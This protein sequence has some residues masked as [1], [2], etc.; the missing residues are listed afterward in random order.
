[1]PAINITDLNNA[2]L[3][4][5]T[6]AGV[7]TSTAPTVTDR[8]GNVKAT[9]FGAVQTLK[10]FNVRGPWA[11]ATAYALKDVY[12]FG[13][14]AYVAVAAHTSTTVAADLASGY[15]TVHQ[16]ATRED[17]A[18]SGGAGL[19][20]GANQVVPSIAGLR[21][22]N[23][24]SASKNAFVTGYYVAGDGGGGPYYYDAA[25]TTTVDNGGTTI[26]A[27][28][29]GRWKL[30]HNGTV[31]VKQFG[32]KGISTDDFTFLQSAITTICGFAGTLIFNPGEYK[33]SQPLTFP[34]TSW[35]ILGGGGQT[36]TAIRETAGNIRLFDLTNCNGP[37]KLIEGITFIGRA[38]GVASS[39][40]VYANITNGVVL[41]DCWFL[42]LSIGVQKLNTS[43][44]VNQFDC[45]YEANT[46]A[47]AYDDGAECI[48]SNP[49]FYKNFTDLYLTGDLATFVCIN[50]NVIGSVGFSIRLISASYGQ[51]TNLTA[52]PDQGGVSIPVLVSLEGTSQHNQFNGITSKGY[53]KMLVKMTAGGASKFNKFTDLRATGAMAQAIEIGA[54]NTDND[55]DGY[56][57]DGCGTAIV[58]A[59]GSN[60]YKTGAI[61]NS[62]SLAILLATADNVE[63]DGLTLLG[64]L[65]NWQISGSVPTV[66][67]DNVNGSV[68]GLTPVRIGSRRAGAYGRTFYGTAI[69]IILDYVV[70]DRVT[71]ITPSV[72][73]PKAWVCTVA[74]TPGTF[75]SEGNL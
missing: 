16:G 58:D 45:V 29:G 67:L 20:G 59:A 28:D 51:F 22:L 35:K 33:I 21:G 60:R 63:F 48:I 61:R 49:T 27:T 57:F 74:G 9:V 32:A 7:A 65:A 1:M 24:A 75:V 12:T 10:A 52:R 50:P 13:G 31:S 44:F 5:N 46:T 73:A 72:G 3:D 8:L 47:I 62:T 11:T 36:Q 34:N 66:W 39:I 19:I 25:D 42:G 71:N 38:T 55:F 41:R 4:V 17:L 26:V 68:A 69:P 70:G 14:Y 43:S 64:N 40:G 6:I 53:G 15:V 37:A 54:G 18:A 56:V 23:K 30:A 2:Q